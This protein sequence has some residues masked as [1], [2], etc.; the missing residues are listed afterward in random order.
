MCNNIKLSRLHICDAYNHSIHIR[1]GMVAYASGLCIWEDQESKVT[2]CYIENLKLAWDTRKKVDNIMGSCGE[3]NW[4][5][6]VK[7]DDLNFIL[8]THVV[9]GENTLMF[10]NALTL[11]SPLNN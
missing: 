6:K 5:I 4:S 10:W 3:M 7:P 2:F 11:L 8:G 9:E 1:L